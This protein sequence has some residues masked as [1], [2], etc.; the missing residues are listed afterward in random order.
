MARAL[1]LLAIVG[2]VHALFGAK[3]ARH[4]HV[5]VVAEDIGGL[6][7]RR[8]WRR[9]PSGPRCQGRGRSRVRRP[10]AR[11]I[12]AGSMASGAQGQGKP[13][14]CRCATFRRG[15]AA[16]HATG[17][18]GSP[19]SGLVERSAAARSKLAAASASAGSAMLPDGASNA[20]SESGARPC[21]SNASRTR[22]AISAPAPAPRP[23]RAP[24]PPRYADESP[25]H[26]HV[27][28]TRAASRESRAAPPR[29]AAI[30]R[31]RATALRLRCACFRPPADPTRSACLARCRRARSPP[32]DS[33]HRCRSAIRR[34]S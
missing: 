27:R 26:R 25:V 32:A 4:A 20:A 23:P 28:S 11:P 10:R 7:E 17:C 15:C 31:R 8:A 22:A 19:S 21:A 18:G 9:A 13:V 1:H 16:R 24:P 2:A 34:S 30:A 5:G 3:R 12:V 33:A 14:A 29:S 6:V